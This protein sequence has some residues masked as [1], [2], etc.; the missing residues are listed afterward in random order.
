MEVYF[1][2]FL[3]PSA[4]VHLHL[5][6]SLFYD[7][8]KRRRRNCKLNAIFK[9]E[10]DA[11]TERASL[12]FQET[13]RPDPLFIDPY[14]GCLVPP[15]FQVNM[16]QHPHKHC[17]ATKFIDDKLLTTMNHTDGLRQVVLLTDGMDTRPYRLNWPAST[18]IFEVSPERIFRKSNQKLKDIGAKI[19]RSCLFYHIPS[20]TSDIQQI[21]CSKGFNGARPSLWAFQRFWRLSGNLAMKEC[22][23]LGELPAWLGETED[24]VESTTRRWMDKLFM[25][26]GFNV[27]IIAYDE[28][29]GNLGTESMVDNYN[30][31]L[32]VAEHLRFS[33]DQM[34]IW[35]T[36]FQR[37]EEEGDEEGF[38]EL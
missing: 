8:K 19:P 27:D 23:F 3:N 26:H 11:A 18:I 21:L 1:L 2:R 38:E 12:R 4:H 35:R 29:A 28:A 31:I 17:L 37:I 13:L 30:N 7:S 15:D 16:K 9:N 22:L 36:E 24:V 25:S 5:V 6:P 10:E 14:V 33:D 34:E 20:E 32:F